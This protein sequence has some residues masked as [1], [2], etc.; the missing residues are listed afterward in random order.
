MSFEN[1]KNFVEISENEEKILQL[2]SLE[3]TY[4]DFVN[5][6][7]LSYS[8]GKI[9]YEISCKLIRNI[10]KEIFKI[11]FYKEKLEKMN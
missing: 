7:K 1:Y 11:N 8:H 10:S 3:I 5:C 9:P 6:I 2:I 4:E